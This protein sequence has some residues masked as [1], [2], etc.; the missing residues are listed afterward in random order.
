MAIQLNFINNSNDANNSQVVIFQ[1]NTATGYDEP[2]VVWK[3]IQ[4]CGHGDN[5]PFEFP[6]DMYVATSDSWGNYTPQLPAQSGQAFQ[7]IRGTLG[8]QLVFKGPAGDIKKV[9]VQNNLPNGSISAHVYKNGKLLAVKTGVTPGQLASFQF[10]PTIF[11]GVTNTVAEGQ[12]MD[13]ATLSNINTEISLLGIKSA[14]IVMTGGGPG[15]GGKPLAFSL[16]N[17]VLV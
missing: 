1:K 6:M 12:I 8:D 17:V 9:Q 11:I 14:D 10:R 13:S 7:M 4:N 5:H 16:Q 15:K 2:A 3:A